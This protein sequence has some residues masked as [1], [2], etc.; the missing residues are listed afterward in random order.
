M[1]D[2]DDEKK[3]EIKSQIRRVQSSLGELAENLSVERA[4]AKLEKVSRE[5]GKLEEVTPGGTP[6][7]DIETFF[8]TVGDGIVSAQTELDERSRHY[9]AGRPDHAVPSVYRIPKASAE[10]SFAMK[11]ESSKKFS[12]LVFSSGD[13]RQQS[14]QHKVSFD[15]LAAPPPPE[16][17]GNLE[18]PRIGLDFVADIGEREQAL[19]KLRRFAK[20]ASEEHKVRIR[21]LTRP[22]AF[23]RTIVFR[24]D[25]HWLLLM[26]VILDTGK[27][28]LELIQV[29]RT[30]NEVLPARHTPP[31][32]LP[33]SLT[34]IAGFLHGLAERQEARLIAMDQARAEG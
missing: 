29:S 3:K 30:T 6:A 18:R 20:T 12:V 26:P 31:K 4:A 16:L 32:T 25:Q 7:T 28:S 21:A 14:Q 23:R 17:M 10:I 13:S 15:I 24:D 2:L 8:R 34:V 1:T 19:E 5:V 33:S 27:L 11:Q 22:K 9:L